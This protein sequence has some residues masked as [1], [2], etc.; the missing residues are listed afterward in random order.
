[1]TE[2]PDVR[3]KSKQRAAVAP[4]SQKKNLK[5]G[6]RASEETR[7]A[8][9]DLSEGDH[10]TNGNNRA[11]SPRSEQDQLQLSKDRSNESLK[12][13][14]RA[15][16]ET[17]GVASATTVKLAEQKEQ[18]RGMDR[19]LADVNDTL[20]KTDRTIRGM[21]SYSG[22]VKN[23]FSS[24]KTQKG[25]T[26]FGANMFYDPSEVTK[27][28]FLFK[29][30]AL[31][32]SWKSRYFVVAKDSA[33]YYKTQEEAKM[34]G[35]PKGSILL[36][37]ATIKTCDSFKS[38][39]MF[40]CLSVYVP[41]KQRTYFLNAASDEDRD[42]WVGSLKNPRVIHTTSPELE[43]PRKSPTSTPKTAAQQ[44]LSEQDEQL[45]ALY[46]VMNNLKDKGEAIGTELDQ[47][48]RMLG[49]VGEVMDKTDQRIQKQAEI[50]KKI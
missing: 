50:V 23:M 30:G 38:D 44:I 29:Q 24:G 28:G 40:H 19:D 2:D 21:E 34:G 3:P 33:H 37:N 45:D 48:N 20:D 47:Q 41:V 32:K 17:D 1:M 12:N 11:V 36:S 27:E 35:K 31:V 42:R 14:I 43:A 39:K 49:H 9:F 22:A 5:A 25:Q 15:A 16:E 4:S 7:V 13:A 26:R 8:L 10:S 6:A 18:I 46:R